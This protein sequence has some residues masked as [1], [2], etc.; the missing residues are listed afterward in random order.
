[1]AD[2]QDTGTPDTGT[3]LPGLADIDV[4]SLDAESW[5]PEDAA[6]W[7]SHVSKELKQYRERWSVF[8][9]AYNGFDDTVRDTLLETVRTLKQ[10]PETVFRFWVD[11]ARQA[12]GDEWL[13]RQIGAAVEQTEQQ[14]GQAEQQ[15]GQAEQT[16][17]VGFDPDDIEK[18]V[19]DLVEQRINELVF[20]QE[21]NSQLSKLGYEPGSQEA[22]TLCFVAGKFY[23]GDLTKAHEALV[24]KLAPPKQEEAEK[25][26]APTNGEAPG[27]PLAGAK[28]RKE[29]INMIADR[30]FGTS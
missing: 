28:D 1:L 8:E 18:R 15:A 26:P 2:I 30:Y 10:D 4:E 17:P 25:P 29:L 19:A 14:A 16:G 27:A 6:R 5:T 11:S 20:R 24:A 9:E 13:M 21:I 12:Y 23:D 22:E 7:R 3:E